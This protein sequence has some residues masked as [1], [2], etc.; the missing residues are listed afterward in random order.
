[1][2]NNCKLA[3]CVKGECINKPDGYECRCYFGF[4][5]ENCDIGKYASLL[6][7]VLTNRIQ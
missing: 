3:R 5:G 4:T 7:D 6:K 2:S 1:M